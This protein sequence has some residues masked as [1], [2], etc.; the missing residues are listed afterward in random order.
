M[1]SQEPNKETI[2]TE[3]NERNYMQDSEWILKRNVVSRMLGK[4]WRS[5]G[6]FLKTLP[7]GRVRDNCLY[8]IIYLHGVT[9]GGQTGR[10]L[11]LLTY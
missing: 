4:A 9:W 6:T 3:I 5:P 2:V 1:L 11:V 7:L 10:T 8:T